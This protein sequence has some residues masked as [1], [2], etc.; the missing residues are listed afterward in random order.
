MAGGLWTGAAGGR[1]RAAQAADSPL[2]RL[3]LPESVLALELVDD[4][5]L[6]LLAAGFES[7]PDSLDELLPRLSVR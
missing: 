2:L 3:L 5:S 4:E 6:L 7:E 1:A